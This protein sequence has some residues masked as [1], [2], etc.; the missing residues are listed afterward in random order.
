[1]FSHSTNK[2]ITYSGT[3]SYKYVNKLLKNGTE[4]WI[5]SPYISFDYA[6]L[7]VKYSKKKKIWLITSHNATNLK[8][9][10]Y[11]ESFSKFYKKILKSAV[12]FAFLAIATYLLNFHLLFGIM[13][14]L[15]LFLGFMSIL[16]FKKKHLPNLKIKFSDKVFIHE[17]IYISDKEAITGSANL[18]FSGQHKNIEHIEL[19]DSAEKI[20]GLKIHFHSLW[21]TL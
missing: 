5:I 9:I 10:K 6:K 13:F 15:T 21:E 20:N 3:D 11:F 7:L 16:S 8:S 4:L 1:M 17:K 2:E 19:T 12:F 18:T 14:A